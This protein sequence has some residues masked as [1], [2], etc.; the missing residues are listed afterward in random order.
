MKIGDT[1]GGRAAPRSSSNPSG[2]APPTRTS[3]N[4]FCGNTASCPRAR[5]WRTAGNCSG[6][7]NREQNRKRI[8]VRP[9]NWRRSSRRSGDSDCC[10]AIGRKPA[11]HIINTT[12]ISRF[13]VFCALAAAHVYPLA[14]EEASLRWMALPDRHLEVDGL[15]WYGEN[16]GE[17]FRLP[18]KLK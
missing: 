17:L 13:V 14:A 18:A 3:R 1:G 12:M 7:P 15:P 9:K 8:P 16:G 5:G 11:T 10:S 4:G 2:S 6:L